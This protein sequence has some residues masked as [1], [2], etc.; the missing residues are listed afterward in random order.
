MTSTLT[1]THALSLLFQH[2]ACWNYCMEFRYVNIQPARNGTE[3][4]LLL[5]SHCQP[6]SLEAIRTR[7]RSTYRGGGIF[8][9]SNH[10]VVHY[11]NSSKSNGFFPFSNLPLMPYGQWS[12]VWSDLTCVAVYDSGPIL[13]QTYCRLLQT[14]DR[15]GP[16]TTI[17]PISPSHASRSN[18]RTHY[19]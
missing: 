14:P 16:T 5:S 8:S 17:L 11:T 2:A 4:M 13:R 10:R 3:L 15:R 6:A 9:L 19:Q 18:G 12:M 7:C 1:S